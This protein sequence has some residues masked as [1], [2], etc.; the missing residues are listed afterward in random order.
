MFLNNKNYSDIFN[1]NV[2][3]VALHRIFLPVWWNYVWHIFKSYLKMTYINLSYKNFQRIFFQR[4]FLVLK[5]RLQYIDFP[6][7]PISRFSN[8]LS[9]TT[10]VYLHHFSS[11]AVRQLSYKMWTFTAKSN[12]II[13]NFRF[14]SLKY[15]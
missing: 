2:L 15:F 13:S 8:Y 11:V 1:I 9:Q 12:F 10:L 3:E 6:M 4:K 14:W 7:S 5:N